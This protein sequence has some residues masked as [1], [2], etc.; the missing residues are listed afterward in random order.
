MT[1][2]EYEAYRAMIA[3]SKALVDEWEELQLLGED[4]ERYC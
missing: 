2:E 4:A 3:R 1:S